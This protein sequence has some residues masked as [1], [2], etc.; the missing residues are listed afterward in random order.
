MAF[1]TQE[2]ASEYWRRNVRLMMIL[3]VGGLL[4]LPRIHQ[5]EFPTLDV[6]AVS[7]RV[8]YLGAAPTE[9]ESAVCIRVEEAVEGTEGIDTVSSNASE[10][11]C[12]V[13][14]ELVAGVDK[15]K[16]A[17]DIKSKVDAIDAFPLKPRSL[18]PPKSASSPPYWKLQFPV[19][20]MSA[21]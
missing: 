8:P 15:T 1:K 5:E 21:P 18:S 19:M 2:D 9:V 7:V 3:M 10:G 13:N 6:D 4:A 14:I 12:S 11:I 20:P 17:N 16:V